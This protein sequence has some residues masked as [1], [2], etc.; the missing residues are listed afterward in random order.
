M[1]IPSRIRGQFEQ[2]ARNSERV[3]R[4]VEA[5]SGWLIL[6]EE[7]L[8]LGTPLKRISRSRIT[9][10]EF[11]RGGSGPGGMIF[12]GGDRELGRVTFRGQ[13][14][15]DLAKIEAELAPRR[16]QLRVMI[17]GDEFGLGEAVRGTVILDWP[18]E[19]PLR[20]IRVGI[21]GT[22]E[23]EIERR[24]GSGDD[25][26]TVTY[27]ECEELMAQEYILFGQRPISWVRA[28]G[29]ALNRALGRKNWPIM[30]GGR[31]E[32]PFE[33]RIPEGALPS[34]SGDHAT[35][36]YRLYANADIP[37]GFDLAFEAMIPVVRR[38]AR[39]LSD[40]RREER[41]GGILTAAVSLDLSLEETPLAP[42]ERLRGRLRIVN[43]SKKA[44]RGVTLA[45]HSTEHASAE[46]ETEEV[47][48]ELASGFLR[49]P[50]PSAAEQDVTFEIAFPPET[51][52]YVGTHSRVHLWLQAKL[53]VARGFD[54]ELKAPLRV[55]IPGVP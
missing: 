25:E 38:N 33:F 43:R 40:Q 26:R 30:P 42:S 27:S 1:R 37:L 11:D 17:E 4:A 12:L 19:G 13:E 8:Y 55:S 44:I 45:L 49:A 18:Q 22:E 29:E 46:G 10:V 15:C 28:V 48:G 52:A 24:E 51:T 2:V 21:A 53:D 6:T 5:Q 3:R 31:H 23:T 50:D 47:S 32:Y 39:V 41:E 36:A 20:G 7:A 34:Y 54:A 16:K 9:G 14:R 35:V